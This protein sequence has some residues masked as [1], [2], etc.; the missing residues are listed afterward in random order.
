MNN[1]G[2][3]VI[4]DA[5]WERPRPIRERNVAASGTKGV[6]GGIR[7]CVALPWASLLERQLKHIVPRSI[8]DRLVRVQNVKIVMA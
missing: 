8:E 7:A 5:C 6:G 2:Q 1:D 3:S 4:F